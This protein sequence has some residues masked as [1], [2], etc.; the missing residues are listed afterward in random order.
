MGRRYAYKHLADKGGARAGRRVLAL[1]F[2]S[3]L[4]F[5]AIM[6]VLAACNL[7][8]GSSDTIAIRPPY[9]YLHRE[10]RSSLAGVGAI[11]AK[12]PVRPDA[13]SAH[14][15]P[16]WTEANPDCIGWIR[17]EGTN[18]DYPVVRGQDNDEYLYANFDGQPSRDGTVFMHYECLEGFDAQFAVLF[19]HNFVDGTMFSELTQYLD[20]GYLAGHPVINVITTDGRSLDYRVFEARSTDVHDPAYVYSMLYNDPADINAYL[21]GEGAADNAQVLLLSTCTDYGGLDE[22]ILVFAEKL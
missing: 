7:F 10:L 2:P 22:R 11:P 8:S 16:A 12:G 19:G 20:D 14:V 9:K 6:G 17:I 15:L 18:I 5:F 21:M 1:L 3:L 13:P 4:C